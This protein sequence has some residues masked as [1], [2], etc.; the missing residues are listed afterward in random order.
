MIRMITVTM[1]ASPAPMATSLNRVRSMAMSLKNEVDEVRN[2]EVM[3][4]MMAVTASQRP[5]SD[6]ESG[7]LMRHSLRY[8][9]S[10][11]IVSPSAET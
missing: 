6:A 7:K 10:T 1:K 9:S 3:S 11:W 4:K 5:M 2:S 8:C